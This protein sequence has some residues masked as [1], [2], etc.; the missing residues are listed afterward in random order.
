L[1]IHSVVMK[2]G[3]LLTAL[4]VGCS[5]SLLPHDRCLNELLDLPCCCADERG[6]TPF[7]ACGCCGVVDT[8]QTSGKTSCGSTCNCA[9]LPDVVLTSTEVRSRG[10]NL[11][12]V[13][14]DALPIHTDV[15]LQ[16]SAARTFRV[17]SC[18]GSPPGWVPLY[19][20]LRVIRI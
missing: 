11:P 17:H 4:A 14:V 13:D 3:V 5:L 7:L 12:G 8:S 10:T 15:P 19:L 20:S 9:G 2:K 18:D 6:G 16:A 1:T